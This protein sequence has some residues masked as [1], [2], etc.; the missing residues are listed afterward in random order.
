MENVTLSFFESSTICCLHEEDYGHI[1]LVT[2]HA[3]CKELLK[4][5]IITL[6]LYNTSM[7]S[8]SSWGVSQVCK[9]RHDFVAL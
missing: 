5:V 8:F 2:P 3:S 7:Y 6:G 9:G 4:I 1:R